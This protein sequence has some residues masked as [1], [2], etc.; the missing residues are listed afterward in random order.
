M[1]VDVEPPTHSKIYSVLFSKVEVVS[2]QA[3][4]SDDADEVFCH[5]GEADNGATMKW[6]AMAA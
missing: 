1:H 2:G 3:I 5:S 6:S 4:S